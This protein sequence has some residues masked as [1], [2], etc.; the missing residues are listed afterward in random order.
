MQ[1]E[2]K[3]VINSSFLDSRDFNEKINIIDYVNIMF[4]RLMVMRNKTHSVLI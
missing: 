1:E 2:T 4:D 3:L